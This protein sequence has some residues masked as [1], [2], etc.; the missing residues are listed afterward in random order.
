MKIWTLLLLASVAGAAPSDTGEAPT[1]SLKIGVGAKA[2]ARID[3]D[4]AFDCDSAPF[5]PVCGSDGVTY[6][7][8]C[9][10]ASAF[11]STQLDSNLLFIQ[12]LGACPLDLS[13][14]DEAELPSQDEQDTEASVAAADVEEVDVKQVYCSLTCKLT[15]DPVCGNDGTTYINDCHLLS[16]K[17]EHPELDKASHGACDEESTKL[18]ALE[19]TLEAAEVSTTKC[20]PMCDRVYA[21]VCGSDGITYANPCLLEYTICHNPSVSL[22][23]SGK[24]PPQLQAARSTLNPTGNGNNGAACIPGPCPYTYA[25]VCGSDGQTHDNLCL[26]ANARCEHPQHSLTVVHDG[27]CDAET[28]LSCLTMT[29]PTFS[30]CREQTEPDGSVVAYCADVCSPE[31]CGEREDCELVDSDCYT[32]PCSPIA[33]CVSKVQDE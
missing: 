31:R 30:E 5:D 32:A 14:E 13:D 17:C 3:C 6:P 8:D 25:P 33:M 1:A 10:F 11:C 29:C 27:E 9:A 7:S 2:T 28:Q 22:F 26:F 16:L 4:E 20:N 18:Q 15:P 24:C 19:V 21:P 12:A 23:S